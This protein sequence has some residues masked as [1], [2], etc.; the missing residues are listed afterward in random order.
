MSI[1]GNVL[2]SKEDIHNRLTYT[3]QQFDD[4]TGQYYL[5]A[6][7]Y[8]PVVGRFTQE[9]IYRGDGLNLYAYC[10]NNPVIYY[11]FS[12]YARKCKKVS[13]LEDDEHRM[14][15]KDAKRY[16]S[17]WNNVEAAEEKLPNYK[18]AIK[19]YDFLGDYYQV[20]LKYEKTFKWGKDLKSMDLDYFN[21]KAKKL[22]E[23]SDNNM[24]NKT[25]SNRNPNV[26]REF[27]QLMREDLIEKHKNNPEKLEKL[28]MELDEM[29]PDHI[30]ELQLNGLDGWE[31][32]KMA[33]KYTNRKIGINLGSQLRSVPENARVKVI[34]EK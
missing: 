21:Y 18:K 8:N 16:D 14:P 23:L 32:L 28:L 5:R 11:D 24:L 2:D 10:G 17:Y 29:D 9:D 1:F 27:K 6:R 34:V 12:G 15:Q 31:N 4:I 26:T 22:E 3:G 33:E 19:K 13:A 30:Q 25:K 20:K 7:F